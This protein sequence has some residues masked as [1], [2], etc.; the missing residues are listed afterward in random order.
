[1][2]LRGVER[3]LPAARR[4]CV[5]G[6]PH[7]RLG[8]PVLCCA[9]VAAFAPVA[10]RRRRRLEGAGG[11]VVAVCAGSGL[12]V[13][14]RQPRFMHGIRQARQALTLTLTCLK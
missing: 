3:L 9:A 6:V 11:G 1:M 8:P 12:G 4:G 10:P 5:G 2:M 13:R 7:E 14:R